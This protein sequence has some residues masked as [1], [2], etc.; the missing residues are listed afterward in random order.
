MR[1]S[2]LW[3]LT[4][5]GLVGGC[6]E[7]TAPQPDQPLERSTTRE[8]GY[9][10]NRDAQYFDLTGVS[11]AGLIV[12]SLTRPGPGVTLGFL[13]NNKTGVSTDL[14]NLG[15]YWTS[16]SSINSSGQV[17]GTA[18]TADGEYHAFRWQNGAMSDL[19]TLP[20][21]IGSYANAISNN[22]KVVGESFK[23]IPGYGARTSRAVLWQNSGTVD[24]GILPRMTWSSA[25]AVNGRGQVV[26][27]SGME[28]GNRQAFLWQRG[29]MIALQGMGGT[30][31]VASGINA[32][33]QIAGAA[34]TSTGDWHAVVWYRGTVTDLGPGS[35]TAI[36]NA[37]V[38]VGTSGE[39]AV[40]WRKGVMSLLSP[41]PDEEYESYIATSI[42]P[43]G[44]VVGSHSSG[45]GETII[46]PM[47]WTIR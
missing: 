4:A 47:V 2:I 11:P 5:L 10:C 29:Q 40:F 34:Q 19:G 6:R 7:T 22:G 36:N 26:G 9:T 12:G 35:A 18:L 33:G 37:G 32:G 13:C 16:P 38:V 44:L 8:V 30:R 1:C 28:S 21:D 42:N 43:S 31:S 15:E 41:V 3:T 24:L 45:D 25:T 27:V 46:S 20:G 23:S 17:V 39:A 14:G